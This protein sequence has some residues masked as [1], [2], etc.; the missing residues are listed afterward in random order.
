[1]PA[2]STLYSGGPAYL[3]WNSITAKLREDWKVTHPDQ[4][5]DIPSATGFQTSRGIM[6]KMGKVSATPKMLISG[7]GAQLAAFFPYTDNRQAGALVRPVSDLPMVIHARNG[8]TSNLG[9]AVTLYAALVSKMPKLTFAPSKPLIDAIEWTY[10]QALG[11][12]VGAAASLIGTS[13]SSYTEP[14]WSIADELFD[15]YT[16]GLGYTGTKTGTTASGSPTVTAI[17]STAKLLVGQPVSGVG[18]PANTTIAAIV[19][20]T[21]ITL[22]ANATANGSGVTLTFAPVVIITDKDGIE[23]EPSCDLEA[24]KPSQEPT[25]DFR[26][27]QVKGILRFRPHNMD[28]DTFYTTYFPETTQVLGMSI[29][30]LGFPASVIGAKT[31]G[32][33]VGG[34]NLAI[35][36]VSLVKSGHEYSTKNPRI[37]KV[38]LQAMDTSASPLFTLGVNA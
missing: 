18:V 34:V 26:Q 31:G 25:R 19:S 29:E 10:L 20:S 22:S 5:F 33:A 7:L 36:L 37:D 24:V 2:N 4:F 35:P 28:V 13:S 32:A 9:L 11:T 6:D 14:T 8:G 12:A 21:S 1:M 3:V 27:G 23:F 15:I 17:A 38:E 30:Q 16:L